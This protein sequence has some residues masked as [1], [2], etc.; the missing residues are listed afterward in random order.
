MQLDNAK[1]YQW[2]KQCNQ[3]DLQQ[4]IPFVVADKTIGYVHKNKLDWFTIYPELELHNQ[5]LLLSNKL[6]DFEQRTLV[7][8]R[9]AKDLYKKN[10]ITSWVGEQYDVATAYGEEVLFTIERAAATLFGIQKYGVHINAYVIK[11]GKYSLWVAKRSQDKPTWPGKL[12][13][14]VA[15]GHGSGMAIKT[16]MLK[17]CQEE[18]GM[19]EEIAKHAIPVASI[20][21]NQ[22]VND[23][24]SRDVLFI[25]DI[26]LNQDFVPINTDGEVEEFYLWPIE[27]VLSIVKSSDKFKT[28]CNLVII[29]FAIRH[30]FIQPDETLYA[31]LSN[32]LHQSTIIG[33]N[34]NQKN[35]KNNA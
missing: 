31:Q 5:Q 13:H 17:E 7:M 15:G 14:L 21:Y 3:Y 22:Q 20:N 4:F 11:Q 26:K 29:D 23:K 33:S 12:D 16:T 19:S 32:G 34:F 1:F 30:G 2:I 10:K 35:E 9:I 25:Y 18:A 8:N 27:K 28:N 24:F 6:Y